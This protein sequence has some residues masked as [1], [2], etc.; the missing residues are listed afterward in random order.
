MF[1]AHGDGRIG[2]IVLPKT[3]RI[4]VGIDVGGARKGFHA[5]ALDNGVYLDRKQTPSVRELTRWVRDEIGAQIVAIDSPCR[6][7]SGK[8][9]RAAERELLEDGIRCFLTPTRR[10][11]VRNTTSFY[12]WMLRGAELFRALEKTHP[13]RHAGKTAGGKC[14]FETFP[15]AITWHLSGGEADAT[16]KR[17]QRLALLRRHGICV[18]ALTN[19]DWIDAALCALAAEMFAAGHVMHFYGNRRTGHIVVP[20]PSR[21]SR[22]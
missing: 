20:V 6:W 19:M 12:Q 18:A 17:P 5:V 15:H 8:S 16:R 11:A 4:V 22:L 14:S 13:L 9:V 10:E 21:T 2:S 1:P 3:K 7:R